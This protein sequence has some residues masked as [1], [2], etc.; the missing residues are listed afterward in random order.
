MV[1]RPPS[2]TLS[3]RKNGTDRVVMFGVKLRMTIC[4]EGFAMVAGVLLLAFCYWCSVV[5]LPSQPMLLRGQEAKRKT[6]DDDAI[7]EKYDV[8]EYLQ[9]LTKK[10]GEEERMEKSKARDLRT[11]LLY[12]YWL[13]GGMS[14]NSFRQLR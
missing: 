12:H 13:R 9:Q 3:Y 11:T 2:L 4:E 6:N 8:T 14:L 1:D 7:L 5:L 10:W